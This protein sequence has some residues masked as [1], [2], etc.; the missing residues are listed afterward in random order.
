M[1]VGK[2]INFGVWRV[3][4]SV[5]RETI[6]VRS[7]LT[8]FPFIYQRHLRKEWKPLLARIYV[9]LAWL[10]GFIGMR[11]LLHLITA[12]QLLMVVNLDV[13]TYFALRWCEHF[14]S[15]LMQWTATMPMHSRLTGPSCRG[16]HRHIYHRSH[17]KSKHT[18]YYKDDLGVQ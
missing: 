14:T 9:T 4:S 3:K 7:Q 16:T 12:Y 6:K 11:H 5:W 2:K 1:E 10:I 13:F 8:F 17:R 15:S 18:N